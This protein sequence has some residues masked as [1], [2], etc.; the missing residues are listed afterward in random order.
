MALA[1]QGLNPTVGNRFMLVFDMYLNLMT[2]L[3]R[4]E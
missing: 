4:L 2:L 1:S 3:F